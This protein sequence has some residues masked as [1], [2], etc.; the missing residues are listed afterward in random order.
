MLNNSK[1]LIILS[2]IDTVTSNDPCVASV[3]VQSDGKINA[4]KCVAFAGT[5]GVC[6][7]TE[8]KLKNEC[9]QF[10]PN[11]AC[12][13]RGKL[14]ECK[15]AT[16]LV[17]R[18][19]A[20]CT[21]EGDDFKYCENGSKKGYCKGHVSPEADCVDTEG[22]C[23]AATDDFKICNKDGKLGVCNREKQCVLPVTGS[24]LFNPWKI[25]SECPVDNPSETDFFIC[26]KAD[27]KIGRCSDDQTCEVHD[28]P[29]SCASG[30][31]AYG[32]CFHT[33]NNG[34]MDRMGRCVK[35]DKG[36]DCYGKCHSLVCKDDFDGT[37]RDT[38]TCSTWDKCKIE[39]NDPSCCVPK[40][41]DAARSKLLESDATRSGL[42]LFFFLLWS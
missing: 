38:G 28:I 16:C 14:G 25:V 13:S 41:S 29:S 4:V 15:D 27:G 8:C 22:A 31:K 9:T 11:K 21:L 34:A 1:C 6:V 36:F 23:A 37:K 26:I 20:D 32:K 3:I 33:T 35:G 18:T 39:G 42:L 19:F 12:V 30:K 17:T 10:T 2:V 7:G 5:D 40:G 24:S